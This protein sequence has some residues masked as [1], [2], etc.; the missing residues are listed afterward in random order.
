MTF[1]SLPLI[2]A[3]SL[4]R[5]MLSTCLR[6]PL[7]CDSLK[8]ERIETI[9]VVIESSVAFLF[10]GCWISCGV[11]IP[12]NSPTEVFRT[13]AMDSTWL[14]VAL[15]A[16]SFSHLVMVP[17]A[18]LTCEA[19]HSWLFSS[20]RRNDLNWEAKMPPNDKTT[21]LLVFLN[22][23]LVFLNVHLCLWSGGN[24]TEH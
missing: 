6:T 11:F 19:N 9:S 16:P 21:P 18:K 3:A 24:S 10:W 13:L 23:H 5:L 15:P 1:F 4:T 17:R 20:L 2:V 14:S 12:S 8:A 22:W 7:F